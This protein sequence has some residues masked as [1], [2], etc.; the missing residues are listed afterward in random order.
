[1]LW[2]I[3]KYQMREVFEPS[4]M[5]GPSDMLGLLGASLKSPKAFL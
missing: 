4:F 3:W 5:F 1:M 2:H